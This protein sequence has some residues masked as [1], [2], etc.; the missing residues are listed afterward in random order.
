V[1]IWDA[2]SGACV[3]GPLEGHTNG[4]S[5]VAYS[6]DGSKVVSG[7]DDRTVRIWDAVSGECVVGPLEGHTKIVTSVAYSPD[8]SKVVSGSGASFILDSGAD[9]KTVRIWDAVSGE[10]VVGPL[11]GH[12][13]YVTS[14]AYSPDGSKVVSGSRDKTVRI[15][16]AV[17]GE[18]VVG[19]L[20]GHTEAARLYIPPTIPTNTLSTTFSSTSDNSS[21]VQL[22]PPPPAGI[23]LNNALIYGGTTAC[24]REANLVHFLRLIQ[25]IK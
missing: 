9:D 20:E 17:S 14:V 2:V 1:R 18:C 25:I 19:P 23:D 24:A 22:S 5:S 13:S 16:D 12:T 8:G 11:E 10:C 4:V 15:W 7:S 3:V 6:P 21:H